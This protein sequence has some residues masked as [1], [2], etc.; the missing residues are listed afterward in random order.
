MLCCIYRVV[1]NGRMIGYGCKCGHFQN[2]LY[3]LILQLIFIPKVALYTTLGFQSEMPP[4]HS[5]YPFISAC[6]EDWLVCYRVL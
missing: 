5:M 2:T 1:G 3:T 4:L 6:A